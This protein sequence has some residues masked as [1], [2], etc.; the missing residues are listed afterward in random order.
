MATAEDIENCANNWNP[1]VVLEG[2]MA[3]DLP[4]SNYQWTMA[5]NDAFGAT[6]FSTAS[7]N[8][9]KAAGCAIQAIKYWKTTITDGNTTPEEANADTMGFLEGL[10]KN[11]KCTPMAST[12]ME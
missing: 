6:D 12:P 5:Y 11:G 10:F 7:S 1:A 2:K 3:A 9:Q 4:Q 8:M